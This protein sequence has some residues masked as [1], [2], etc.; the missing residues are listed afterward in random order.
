MALLEGSDTNGRVKMKVRARDTQGSSEVAMR[1]ILGSWGIIQGQEFGSSSGD[2]RD[3]GL[4][5]LRNNVMK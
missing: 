4:V 1:S 3:D 2:P 5:L